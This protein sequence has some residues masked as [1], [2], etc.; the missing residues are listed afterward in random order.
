[1]LGGEGIEELTVVCASLSEK[2]K[3]LSALKLHVKTMNA[4]ATAPVKPQHL[5]VTTAYYYYYY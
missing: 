1:L 4:T 3:W 2:S 5:Q